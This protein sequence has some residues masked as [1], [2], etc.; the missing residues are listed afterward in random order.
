MPTRPEGEA[1]RRRRRLRGVFDLGVAR[2]RRRYQGDPRRILLGTLRERF[3]RAHLKDSPGRVL[4]LGP[5]PGR[6]TAVIRRLARGP[7]I[8]VDLSRRSLKAA[9]RSSRDGRG[10]PR[11]H[12]IQG[13]GEHLPLTTGS[14]D[15]AV[16]LGNILGFAARDAPKVMEELRR[17][18]RPGGLLV[19]DFPSPA[20][21]VQEFLHGLSQDRRLQKVLRNPRLYLIDSVLATGYQPFAPARLAKFECQFFTAGEARETLARHGFETLDVM[22]VA[23]LTAFQDRSP[24]IAH[25]EK[26]TWEAL[27]RLEECVGRRPG[28]LEMGHGFVVAGRRKGV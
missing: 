28:T 27:L 13:A 12:W 23:P 19:A 6:F 9:R 25:Q 14:V 3:L 1:P 4:E 5:G 22:S 16:A 8:A 21:A 24:S 10:L 15:A 7:V 26:R 17:V 11:V 20:G 2:E 18:L